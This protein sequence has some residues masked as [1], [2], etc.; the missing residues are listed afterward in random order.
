MNNRHLQR[1]LHQHIYDADSSPLLIEIELLLLTFATGIQDAAAYPDYGCFASNQTGN[2][3]FLA[4]A[5][6][7]IG[8]GLFDVENIGVS[9][10][11]FLTGSYVM[12]QLGN[13]VGPRRKIWLL[14][15]NFIQVI[16]VYAA[17]I[18]QWKAGVDHSGPITL[19]ILFLLS[20]SSGAQVA[21]TRPLNITQIT[22]VCALTRPLHPM[23][24]KKKR[25]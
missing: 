14:F 17:A 18:V 24:R 9:L 10:G 4:I 19:A 22:T 15:T 11:C 1:L 21:M 13:L 8:N 20:F 7:K 23:Q 2:T 3:I 12:G 25:Y 5:V 16:M 6:A